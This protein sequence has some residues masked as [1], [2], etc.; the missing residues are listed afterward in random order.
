MDLPE[1]PVN[2]LGKRVREG[3]GEGE[4]G[5]YFLHKNHDTLVFRAVLKESL[6]E[7]FP[8]GHVHTQVALLVSCGVTSQ[9]LVR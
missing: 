3:R 9:Q 1:Y 6:S 5:R 4:G 2:F 7:G 8:L